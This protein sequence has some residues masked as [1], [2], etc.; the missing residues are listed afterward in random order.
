MPGCSRCHGRSTLAAARRFGLL[1]FLCRSRRLR[2]DGAQRAGLTARAAPRPFDDVPH[3][4]LAQRGC[5]LDRGDGHA[6]AP[7]IAR[8]RDSESA[9]APLVPEGG[10]ALVQHDLGSASFGWRS[11]L[12][13]EDVGS[14]QRTVGSEPTAQGTAGYQGVDLGWRPCGD[15][16]CFIRC[17]FRGRTGNCAGLEGCG[18]AWQLRQIRR[19]ACA[20]AYRQQNAKSQDG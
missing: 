11:R 17:G 10:I 16:R 5:D 2:L 19:G 7:G 13:M 12:G 15:G 4:Q 1:G 9:R 14:L 20:G 8:K 3:H 18:A 6:H